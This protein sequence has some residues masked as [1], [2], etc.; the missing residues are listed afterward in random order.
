MNANVRAHAAEALEREEQKRWPA[1]EASGQRVCV[2][3][4]QLSAAEALATSAA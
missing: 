1:A 4:P 3:I 2:C